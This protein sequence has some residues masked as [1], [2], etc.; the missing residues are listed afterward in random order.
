[1]TLKHL[2]GAPVLG[3]L[4]AAMAVSTAHAVTLNPANSIEDSVL[5]NDVADSAD[6][7]LQEGP[8]FWGAAF[9]TIDDAGKAVFNFANTSG[10]NQ[11]VAVSLGTVLQGFGGKF[12]DG[13]TARWVGGESVHI[14]EGLLGVFEISKA[15]DVGEVGILKIIFGDPSS[16]RRSSP[17]IQLQVSSTTPDVSAVPVPPALALLASGL[18]GMVVLARRRKQAS[19]SVS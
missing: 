2:L 17:G 10:T 16:R 1:M 11:D 4:L 9:K 12:K 14:A 19:N 15:L 6:Y 3:V 5:S 13:V 7:D 18:M 8:Y